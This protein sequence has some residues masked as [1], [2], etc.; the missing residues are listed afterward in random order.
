M[1][2]SLFVETQKNV[3]LNGKEKLDT[4]AFETTFKENFSN[5]IPYLNLNGEEKIR[6]KKETVTYKDNID[7][8]ISQDNLFSRVV[9]V[10][11]KNVSTAISILRE[12]V[13][14][15]FIRV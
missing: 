13:N 11:N 7:S 1:I 10:S 15:E 2:I 6:R 5:M 14:V 4:K 9:E 8:P 3:I 12:K